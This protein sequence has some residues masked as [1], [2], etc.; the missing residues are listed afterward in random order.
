MPVKTQVDATLILTLDTGS[1]AV[2]VECQVINAAFTPAAPGES[3]PIPIACGDTVSEPSDP[4][5]GSITGEVFK[6]WSADGIT[7]LLAEAAVAGAEMDYV[8]T[9]NSGIAGDEAS[10]SGKATVPQFGIDFAP[11]KLGRHEMN[12]SLTTSVLAP[13]V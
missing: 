6:D 9:E 8:Y 13:I 1:G 3:T 5:N 4:Q 11:S 10:W 7:R 12:L 2:A